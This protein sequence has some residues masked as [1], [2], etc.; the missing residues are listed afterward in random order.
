M[1]ISPPRRMGNNRQSFQ[2]N[3]ID[4]PARVLKYGNS[5]K[6]MGRAITNEKKVNNRDS[7]R[8]CRTKFPR[9]D[10]TTFRKPTSFARLAD[11]AVDRFTKLMIAIRRMNVAMPPNN[12]M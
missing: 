2:G 4:F 8:N 9:I 1:A 7:V 3:S 5:I 10:P 12:H 11:F 6:V